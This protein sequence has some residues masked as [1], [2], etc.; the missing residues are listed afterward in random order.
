MLIKYYLLFVFGLTSGFALGQVKNKA[1]DI[2]HA[3]DRPIDKAFVKA[4]IDSI[5]YQAMLDTLFIYPQG[6]VVYKLNGKQ[7][8]NVKQVKHLLSQ[9][10]EVMP[11]VFKKGLDQTGRQLIEINYK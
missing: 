8:T 9:R 10:K 4:K 11:R 2:R 7:F 5:S 1:A 3:P 6:S